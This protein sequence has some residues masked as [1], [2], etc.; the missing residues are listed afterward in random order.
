MLSITDEQFNSIIETLFLNESFGILI[1]ET[2]R[3][4]NL[5]DEEIIYITDYFQDL[6]I[7][8]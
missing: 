2:L 7:E 5:S 6:L 1:E 3:G 4:F 8:E